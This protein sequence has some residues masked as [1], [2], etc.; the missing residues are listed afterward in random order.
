M[1]QTDIHTTLRKVMLKANTFGG[2]L[3]LI[4]FCLGVSKPATA[5]D[6]ISNMVERILPAVVTLEVEIANRN[7]ANNTEK[8]QEE[9]IPPQVEEFFRRFFG[10][11]FFKEQ[12][13][14]GYDWNSPEQN[15]NNLMQSQNTPRRLN[16]AYGSGF[17]ISAQGQV[18]TN[19]HVI[20]RAAKIT[21]RL[22]NDKDKFEATVIGVDP[23]TDIAVLKINAD[24]PL[25]FVNFGDS[26]AVRLGEPVVV[27]GNPLGVGLSVS[28]GVISAKYRDLGGPYD[29]FFQTDASINLGNSGGPLFNA[30]GEVIG[31]NTAIKTTGFSSGS[32]GIGFSISSE[33]VSRVVDQIIDEGKV[34]RGYLGIAIGN[35]PNEEFEGTVRVENVYRD[36][37]AFKGGLLPGDVIVSLEG[38]VATSVRDFIQTVSNNPP[39]KKIT[40]EV[41]RGDEQLTIEVELGSRPT[42]PGLANNQQPLMPGNTLLGMVLEEVEG[43]DGDTEIKIVSVQQDSSAARAGLNENDIIYFVNHQKVNS[44]DEV[45]EKLQEARDD[46]LA[47]LPLIIQRGDVLTEI[48]I[49]LEN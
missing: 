16:L 24:Q 36:G 22:S 48:I 38:Y 34:S 44:I 31:V 5:H 47:N 13:Q 35:P 18:V 11:E 28:K 29:N 23:E 45:Q 19:Y 25:D 12:R 33:V 2:V 41:L 4:M 43:V 42:L 15:E 30:E 27:I 26:N 6:D 3:L 46:N 9:V 17:I 37:P 21:V 14:R 20:E 1:I 32:I 10:D 40:L 8:N 7:V 49:D 39:G